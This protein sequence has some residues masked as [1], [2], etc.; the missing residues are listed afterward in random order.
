MVARRKSGDMRTS[1]TVTTWVASTSSWISPRASISARA[2]RISSPTRS[3]HGEGPVFRWS[4]RLAMGWVSDPPGL[5]PCAPTVKLQLAAGPQRVGELESDPEGL[6]PSIILQRPLDGLDIVALDDIALADVLVVG[7]GHAAFLSCGHFPH[8]VLE[9]LE[10]RERAF[11]DHHVVADQPHLCAAFDL[12]FGHAAAGHLTDLGDVEHLQDAGVAEKDLAHRR[13]EQ[14]RH[15]RL[16]VIHQIVDD[17][18]V[19]DL[20]PAL[21]RGC[22]GLHVGA[23]VEA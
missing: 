4:C 17:V 18:V 14:T 6:T 21:V 22:L 13:R 10:R 7:E 3:C 9:A 8:L 15:C 11:V 5:T 23:D 20:D 19:A 1:E 16:N 2:W 12:A